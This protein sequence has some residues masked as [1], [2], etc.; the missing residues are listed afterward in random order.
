MAKR[1]TRR[2][3]SWGEPRWYYSGVED[4]I[5]SMLA[6]DADAR[7]VEEPTASGSEIE[8][9]SLRWLVNSNYVVWVAA[10][11]I[12]FMEG[13]SWNL[14]HAK[15]LYD[16][17]ESGENPLFEIPAG[18][19]DRISKEDVIRT[20]SE[21]EA[22]ELEYQRGMEKPWSP[23]DVGLLTAQLVDGN[24]RALAA[25]AAGEHSIPVIVGENY[26]DVVKK[27]EWVKVPKRRRNSDERLRRLEREA[28]AG[29]REAMRELIHEWERRGL[30]PQPRGAVL[31]FYDHAGWATPPGRAKSALRL[32][33]A[34][35]EAE[36]RWWRVEWD[37]ELGLED[38]GWSASLL[39]DDD[40]GD[41]LASVGGIDDESYHDPNFRRVVEA[42]L[43]LEA[44]ASDA[45]DHD[46]EF[47]LP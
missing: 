37:F 47:P 46:Y 41:N 7:H 12:Q 30:V 24:H 32:A 15:A 13:N 26:R 31:F 20:A 29:D 5:E 11:C 22:D 21:Y 8:G 19:V 45:T 42:E 3:N 38:D 43:A 39:V 4:L 44:L 6:S 35:H 25:I 40:E 16:L 17:I 28:N 23:K 36:V 14:E 27:K 10:D 9:R 2:R 18:R 34:E 1:V 33:I